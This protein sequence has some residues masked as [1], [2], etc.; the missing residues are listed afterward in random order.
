M[1]SDLT[2]LTLPVANAVERWLA[3]GEKRLFIGG[4]WVDGVEGRRLVTINPSTGHELARVAEG[5]PEDVDRAVR[6]ARAALEGP[7]GGMS[8]AQRQNLMLRLADVIETNYE[9][10]RLLQALEMGQ[11]ISNTSPTAAADCVQ[12]LRY[13]AGWAT[14]LCGETVS[15]TAG[16]MLTFTVR[17]PVGVVGSIIAWNGPLNA[18]L[19]K[20]APV[21]ATGCTTVLKP[22]EQAMLTVLRL[23]EL[24]EE[25][26]IPQGTVNIVPGLGS[27]AGAALAAHPDVD[28]IAFTGST[29]TGRSI[30]AAATGNLKRVSLEL[31]GKSPHIIF[32]DAN[33]DAAIPAAAMGV[34]A[35]SG[36]LCSA[37]SRVFVQRAVYEMV[38][39]QVAAIAD[40]LKVG[41]SIDPTTEIGPVVSQAQLD[42]VLSYISR[43]IDEGAKLIAGGERVVEGGLAA[44]YFVRPTV[45]ADV[46]DEMAIA[47]EEI[48]GPVASILPFDDVEEVVERANATTFGL[49]GGLWTRDMDTALRVTRGVKAG[50]FW[51]NTY[52]KI[53]AAMPFG[54]YRA[55]GW[56]RELSEHALEEYLNVKA[57]WMNAS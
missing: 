19:W 26:G 28:K 50:V 13:F 37:G 8:P 31:G 9:E 40:K 52:S 12:I 14:K 32:A 48:F 20:L 15:T 24:I 23:G 51:I 35:N 46:R 42:R 41:L 56:G 43:G 54:G 4:A 10:L 55:S 29:A 25:A 34:F 57:V 18:S 3:G 36:Q 47:K 45:F 22:A 30:V 16:P 1:A 39:E 17:E 38:V 6:A 44:G 2:G 33:L 11:P 21:L 53:D 7:W 49:A 27:V 5:G